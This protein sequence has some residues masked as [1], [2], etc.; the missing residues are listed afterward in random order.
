[1]NVQSKPRLAEPLNDAAQL[2]LIA[3]LKTRSIALLKEALFQETQ[4]LGAALEG[5]ANTMTTLR[6]EEPNIVTQQ[7]LVEFFKNASE[8]AFATKDYDTTTLLAVAH[9]F[10]SLEEA[11]FTPYLDPDKLSEALAQFNEPHPVI[12]DAPTPIS[13]PN[14]ESSPLFDRAEYILLN[15]G[16]AVAALL[17]KGLLP[18]RALRDFDEQLG[19]LSMRLSGASVN[20]TTFSSDDFSNL[21]KGVLA[22]ATDFKTQIEQI[23]TD[24]FV[25]S[26]TPVAGGTQVLNT[27]LAAFDSMLKEPSAEELKRYLARSGIIE[28]VAVTADV[29]Q[30]TLT[31][32]A[33]SIA[34]ETP[35]AAP[36]ADVIKDTLNKAYDLYK[37]AKDLD[38]LAVTYLS[39]ENSDSL[40]DRNIEFFHAIRAAAHSKEISDLIKVAIKMSDMIAALEL[41]KLEADERTAPALTDPARLA[42]L[43]SAL[44]K[45]KSNF[46]AYASSL[47]TTI[48]SLLEQPAVIEMVKAAEPVAVAGEPAVGVSA[49]N[50]ASEAPSTEMT[51]ASTVPVL[52][53]VAVISAI[54]DAQ[55][56]YSQ[57]NAVHKM[58]AELLPSETIQTW[59]DKTHVL[60]TAILDAGRSKD[61][62]ALTGVM[63]FTQDLALELARL[64]PEVKA[65]IKDGQDNDAALL[66]KFRFGN[67]LSGVRAHQ[68][69]L[70]KMLAPP[71]KPAA[72]NTPVLTEDSLNAKAEAILKRVFAIRIQEKD[73]VALMN[74]VLQP[75]S[76]NAV[77]DAFKEL[78]SAE[79]KAS[80]IFK[81]PAD[82]ERVSI[83]LD[84]FESAITN[85]FE[86]PAFLA[87]DS[88]S[89]H[90][91][92]ALRA[93]FKSL[94]TDT[95]SLKV[96]VANLLENADDIKA[97][98]MP[99]DA[100]PNHA[101]RTAMLQTVQTSI[102]GIEAV[103]N[104]ANTQQAPEANVDMPVLFEK[105]EVN[106]GLEQV[107]S[108]LGQM[109]AFRD[110][111]R[112]VVSNESLDLIEA[113]YKHVAH[114]HA[115][116]SANKDAQGLYELSR[117]L[118]SFCLSLSEIWKK[119]PV[120]RIRD[121]KYDFESDLGNLNQAV[122][123]VQSNLDAILNTAHQYIQTNT[124]KDGDDLEQIF[125][126][127]R[128]VLAGDDGKTAQQH[129]VPDLPR[130]PDYTLR[131][132]KIDGVKVLNDTD[133]F[134]LVDTA[135]QSLLRQVEE[136]AVKLEQSYLVQ[137]AANLRNEASLFESLP[138]SR[139]DQTKA[140]FEFADNA[141]SLL[142]TLDNCAEQIKA[143]LEEAQSET[144][145]A[146]LTVIAD[147]LKKAKQEIFKVGL[148]VEDFALIH[149]HQTGMAAIYKD[150]LDTLKDIANVSYSDKDNAE[151][152]EKAI[153]SALVKLD[154]NNLAII[155]L[156]EALEA[157]QRMPAEVSAEYASAALQ[158]IIDAGQSNNVLLDTPDA[159][160][161]D[162]NAITDDQALFHFLEK[163]GDSSAIPLDIL[164]AIGNRYTNPHVKPAS[165]TP[166]ATYVA[167]KATPAPSFTQ[168]QANL[169]KGVSEALIGIDAILTVFRTQRASATATPGSLDYATWL[170]KQADAL[171]TDIFVGHPG[172]DKHV[173]GNLPY[174]QHMGFVL[175]R[176]E[177]ADEGDYHTL[178]RNRQALTA[179]TTH[180]FA[181][182]L[183]IT[184]HAISY[185]KSRIKKEQDDAANQDYL[186]KLTADIDT[187]NRAKNNIQALKPL[188]ANYLAAQTAESP[189]YAAYFT[190][191]ASIIKQHMPSLV[192]DADS[193]VYDSDVADLVG[194]L[195]AIIAKHPQALEV[196][197][198][199]FLGIDYHKV[200]KGQRGADKFKSL[201][202]DKT[203][204][205][206]EHRR[207]A[208]ELTR[209]MAQALAAY[210]SE[211]KEIGKDRKKQAALEDRL[212]ET[213]NMHADSIAQY[214][215]SVTAPRP[216]PKLDPVV[217]AQ[218]RR[219]ALT[220]QLK[221]IY[222]ELQ[223]DGYV[224]VT[225]A[226]ILK[227]LDQHTDEEV[228]D[229]LAVLKDINGASD[230]DKERREIALI[231]ILEAIAGKKPAVK[232]SAA[233]TPDE[234]PETVSDVLAIA[235]K[236]I[237]AD[238][239]GG[240]ASG[241]PSDQ[242]VDATLDY[243][244]S[245]D[246]HV[247]L[248]NVHAKD[249]LATLSAITIIDDEETRR[250]LAQ[251]V[252]LAVMEAGD[253]ARPQLHI[254][255][256]E[257]DRINAISD[258]HDLKVYLLT[259]ASEKLFL[260]QLYALGKKVASDPV[261]YLGIVSEVAKNNV[262]KPVAGFAVGA[263][264][265]FPMFAK[266]LAETMGQRW[267]T[268]GLSAG[269]GFIVKS[270]LT[271]LVALTG[272]GSAS[273]I[274][275]SVA[276]V[277]VVAGGG[278]M[279]G[280]MVFGHM[281]YYYKKELGD[282]YNNT[283]VAWKDKFNVFKKQWRDLRRAEWQAFE[284][285][286]D[287]YGDG[288]RN[289]QNWAAIK[290]SSDILVRGYRS[291]MTE[292][293]HTG[294]KTS[295]WK[296][297][298]LLIQHMNKVD[299]H[300]TS[301][302]LGTWLSGLGAGTGATLS[303][304]YLG[305]GGHTGG[306]VPD[307]DAVP[308]TS[309]AP[310]K[311]EAGTNTVE[312][313][314][315]AETRPAATPT[316][317]AEAVRAP[318]VTETQPAPS[319]SVF[320]NRWDVMQKPA[321][322][323]PPAP[324]K[325]L[326]IESMPP[327]GT[328]QPI[329]RITTSEPAWSPHAAP[330]EPAPAPAA[331]VQSVPEPKKVPTIA[332][333]PMEAESA[334]PHVASRAAP[335]RH[336]SGPKPP[337]RWGDATTPSGNRS[338]TV[339]SRSG[340]RS[341]AS[342]GINKHAPMDLQK[343]AR[344]GTAPA[345]APG[346]RGVIDARTP[347]GLQTPPTSSRGLP[348]ELRVPRDAAPIAPLRSP[349]TLEA[350][351]NEIV[352]GYRTG[353]F[354]GTP[355]NAWFDEARGVVMVADPTDPGGAAR[356]ISID[357]G[358]NP[359]EAITNGARSVYNNTF[360]RL[361]S[362]S[363]DHVRETMTPT[364]SQPAPLP[365]PKP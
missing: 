79:F 272:L 278:L 156:Q 36:N 249:L 133:G 242:E 10:P 222:Q 17:G 275:L 64:E 82:F 362:G 342:Q 223:N 340:A 138:T 241:W 26:D 107:G 27:A 6:A 29:S 161:K 104:T 37:E 38:T 284:R 144:E 256:S 97:Q 317:E 218:K 212:V 320:D 323:T 172:G 88:S 92:F 134:T 199:L 49:S 240:L 322:A 207:Q 131:K 99:V 345:Q 288:W 282:A 231:P 318:T 292:L 100:D 187:L 73:V 171:D 296:R 217:E 305:T 327:A 290:N 232:K 21:T 237:A 40:H 115:D 336:W 283:Q 63:V 81:R 344:A 76:R 335:S 285:A 220:G 316:P 41:A 294:E 309:V 20:K 143:G 255:G 122:R 16:E 139:T 303:H 102:D 347:R 4:N 185:L 267:G 167:P 228:R 71:V 128:A 113:G 246:T 23:F 236:E 111:V 32:D 22:S 247:K 152:T 116:A 28:S 54:Q 51:E 239:R 120:F 135:K 332:I 148:A 60:G 298:S 289:G 154:L 150:V 70:Q 304:Y 346:A 44:G 18:A 227:G 130:R 330:A 141:D 126:R 3:K 127:I 155:D 349:A 48:Q 358:K 259:R 264:E 46:D 280:R 96:D 334:T 348:P 209:N 339:E 248:D 157:L 78:F 109:I 119:D 277:A 12:A 190:G 124:G 268:I 162:I 360:G 173:P 52:N 39:L 108:I 350:K 226:D 42:S 198:A 324:A 257:L 299:E 281:S 270:G 118:D 195:P 361:M 142:T 216:K 263:Y 191:M 306:T 15:G 85:A 75:E 204:A 106:A 211:S 35:T 301:V 91:I 86:D 53:A 153:L 34:P 310:G 208:M 146:S 319:Q 5:L 196:V 33:P 205:D 265:R 200:G 307:A 224:G 183:Q 353:Q 8:L 250:K 253:P 273:A 11:P 337:H 103:K 313:P 163:R 206:T 62:S 251:G 356:P 50:T 47:N 363:T 279:L 230:L 357:G 214:G 201:F 94:L 326:I 184:D 364:I 315:L 83:A 1:M 179:L 182:L 147:N 56:T 177:Q 87:E 354:D 151:Q 302:L 59:A 365:R 245:S 14:T 160:W 221:A 67:L 271:G 72:P 351:A 136:I 110:S 203:K 101:E 98:T 287:R 159:Q 258:M 359:F 2:D 234:Q 352:R 25:D 24:G 262:I 300:A 176:M 105:E 181:N 7:V 295:W 66:F 297:G 194:K 165:K 31:V 314:P 129:V 145:K 276:S 333:R 180:R 338:V 244:K 178:S 132:F 43:V 192:K 219:E 321:D 9:G 328:T 57:S 186:K 286:S 210:Y 235:L 68:S 170:K 291:M 174:A 261:K 61:K 274:A 213:I 89:K 140:V 341:G 260:A 80:R 225:Q 30:P 197:H 55:R 13:A 65:L 69:S 112:D 238:I 252:L 121:Q 77:A 114:A 229:L 84:K 123:N 254:K 45:V 311:V 149:R 343:V 325:P 331:P 233:I 193:S 90:K 215:A 308:A 169:Q 137:T 243:L 202:N 117:A 93:R 329:P 95:Q 158:G 312:G 269:T 293:S 125:A 189:A 19:A 188:A 166:R 58:A 175:Q 164:L 74:V 168:A 355:R 266:G